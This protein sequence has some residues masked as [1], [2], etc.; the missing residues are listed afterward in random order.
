MHYEDL[1]E[2]G[3]AAKAKILAEIVSEAR[4]RSHVLV[5]DYGCGEAWY[6]RP[7]LEKYPSIELIGYDPDVSAVERARKYL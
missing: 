6:W 3:N 2:I 5:F 1:V 7:V 4:N